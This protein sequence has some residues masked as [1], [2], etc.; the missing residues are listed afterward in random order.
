[1][2]QQA[3]GAHTKRQE[4]IMPSEYIQV[5]PSSNGRQIGYGIREA[6]KPE[7]RSKAIVW[8]YPLSGCSL[9]V[10][11]A[12]ESSTNF[13]CSV[14]SVDRPDCGET[15]AL[16]PTEED[17]ALQRIRGHIDDVLAV[18]AHHNIQHVYVLGV[19]IGHVYGLELCRRLISEST[20]PQLMGLTLVAPFVSTA[21]PYSWRVARIGASV[22]DF[23]L[24]GAV[25]S[26]T[27]LMTLVLPFV[28]TP[29]AIANLVSPEEQ[30][31]FGWTQEDFEEA[32]TTILEMH[33]IT[34]NATESEARLGVA[35]SWQEHVCDKFAVESGYGLLIDEDEVTSGDKPLVPI[36]IH[37]SREDKLAS[38][39][40]V[41]W[42]ARRCY[43]G[44]NVITVEEKI[45][46]HEV[47]TMLG[48]SRN[49]ILL[50]RIA[51]DW[52]L[53]PHRE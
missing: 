12:A 14:L 41:E 44:T 42:I 4:I 35:S 33:E 28:L 29:S 10:E 17:F 53:M 7:D 15:S 43:G 46:S 34:K 22:P 1:L 31:E 30:E 6:T 20:T 37:A 2:K 13:K 23:V 50:H 21:S 8:F 39:E 9:V 47:M 11:K 38:L 19:C 48:H 16:P 24:R 36:R 45:H 52:G 27:S 49:P 40:S 51:S 25:A 3:T 32:Y 18:L 26:L 5:L